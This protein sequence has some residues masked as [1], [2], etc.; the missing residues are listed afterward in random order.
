MEM[1]RE[2]MGRAEM[3]PVEMAPVEMEW[4]DLARRRVAGLVH[5]PRRVDSGTRLNDF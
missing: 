5:L 3:A 4:A 2:E 1:G